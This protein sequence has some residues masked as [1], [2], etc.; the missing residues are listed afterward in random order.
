MKFRPLHDW[1]VIVRTS[2]VTSNLWLQE[3]P[4]S[5]GEVIAIGPRVREVSVGDL[6][7]FNAYSG[8]DVTAKQKTVLFINESEISFILN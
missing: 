3:K 4:S 8:L 7:Q 6:V 5:Q 2:P 1:V